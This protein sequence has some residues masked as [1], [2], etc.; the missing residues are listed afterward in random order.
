LKALVTG[1]TGFIG[2]HLTGALAGMSEFEVVSVGRRRPLHGTAIHVDLSRKGWTAAL[3]QQADV[4]FHLAQSNRYRDFP[5]GVQDVCAI[6]VDATVELAAWAR[7]AGIQRLIYA[8]TGNVYGDTQ[9]P[10]DEHAP[11]CAQSM[12]AAS[13][14]AAE[15]LLRPFSNSFEVLIV[16]LFGIYGPGQAGMLFPTII[17]RVQSGDEITLARGVGVK[18]NPLYVDDCVR[19]LVALARVKLRTTYDVVNVGGTET[20]TLADVVLTIES[21]VTRPART[22]L[23]AEQPISIVG[24]VQKLSQYVHLESLMPLREGLSRTI[25]AM[26]TK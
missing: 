9:A 12:Y 8:S 6:N 15:T 14:L 16:R 24:N 10:A 19:I 7:S 17:E 2:R 23:T 18:I 25:A 22:K 11:T 5:E 4:V 1:A 21:L 3:P 20:V 26:G 13:K